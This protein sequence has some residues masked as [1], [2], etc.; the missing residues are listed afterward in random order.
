MAPTPSDPRDDSTPSSTPTP[1]PSQPKPSGPGQGRGA[2]GERLV[3]HFKIDHQLAPQDKAQ[4]EAL[5]LDPRS[6]VDSL[7]KWLHDKGYKDMSRGSVQRHRRQFELDV[8]DI[9]QDARVAGQFAALARAQGG[10]TALADAGQFRI[11]QLF[12]EQLFRMDKADDRGGKEWLEFV[13]AMATVVASRAEVEVQREQSERR[14]REAVELI[15]S[16]GKQRFDGVALSDKVRRILGVPL[17]GEPTPGLPTENTRRGIGTA[18]PL[19]RA[20][21]LPDGSGGPG[22]GGDPSRN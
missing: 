2:R 18:D 17:P 22:M 8:K 11:E 4:Y 21:E 13:R 1:E 16:N 10:P 6:T 19:K 5:L 20:P 14:A 3:R 9:R 12:V 15:K 7:L